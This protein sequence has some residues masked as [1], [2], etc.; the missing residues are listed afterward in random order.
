LEN[1]YIDVDTV[2]KNLKIE[3]AEGLMG[4]PPKGN[5]KGAQPAKVQ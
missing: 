3:R 4:M 2:E 5:K 1:I